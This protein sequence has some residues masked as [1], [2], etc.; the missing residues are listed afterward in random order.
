MITACGFGDYTDEDHRSCCLACSAAWRYSHS[1][2]GAGLFFV[3]IVMPAVFVLAVLIVLHLV[4]WV[5]W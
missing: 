2:L 1:R 5:T 3:E 4:G